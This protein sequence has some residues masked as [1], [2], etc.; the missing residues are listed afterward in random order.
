MSTGQRRGGWGPMSKKW[1]FSRR[2][3]SSSVRPRL[4]GPAA[5][6]ASPSRR[7]CSSI[8]IRLEIPA[9]TLEA[10]SWSADRMMMS[11]MSLPGT[12]SRLMRFPSLS[13]MATARENSFCS[14][15]MKICSQVRAPWSWRTPRILLP[16]R[17]TMS[18]CRVLAF[19]RTF[20]RG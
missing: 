17:T 5:S 9:T 8:G 10:F 1:D 14:K 7:A 2:S 16:V 20:S 19:R 4:W 12:T 13:A 6:Q 3:I 11:E 15:L 18:C